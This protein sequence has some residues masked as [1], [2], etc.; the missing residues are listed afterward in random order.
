MEPTFRGSYAIPVLATGQSHVCFCRSGH[1]VGQTFCAILGF[2]SSRGGICVF[3]EQ[4][5]GQT[6]I[7]DHIFFRPA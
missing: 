1:I 7:F 4:D 3:A 6:R 2:F 5:K